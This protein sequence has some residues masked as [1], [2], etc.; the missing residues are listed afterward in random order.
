MSRRIRKRIAVGLAVALAVVS[1]V[2]LARG[3]LPVNL[4]GADPRIEVDYCPSLAQI[5][6]HLRETGK[7]YKPTVTCTYEISQGIDPPEGP[8]PETDRPHADEPPPEPAPVLSFEEA[9][10]LYDPEDDP[11]ILLRREQD[12]GWG[13]ISFALADP[14]LPLAIEKLGIQTEEQYQRR[15]QEIWDLA[16][17]FSRPAPNQVPGAP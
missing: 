10:R 9:Q 1:T 12:G 2:S 7:D 17:S 14:E 4:G 15:R 16:D 8:D 6:Q 13:A 5:E 11:S 3:E